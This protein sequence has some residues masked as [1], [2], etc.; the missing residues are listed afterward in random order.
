MTSS[1]PTLVVNALGRFVA[2]VVLVMFL[3]GLVLIGFLLQTNT[4]EP[5]FLTD[6]V[7]C[8]DEAKIRIHRF[9]TTGRGTSAFRALGRFLRSLGYD[10]LPALWDV[11]RGR[12]G[13]IQLFHLN[14]KQ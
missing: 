12:I 7:L 3:P 8:A 2:F 4:D 10:D 5:I 13:L 6:E 9:R 14:K 1:F 11:L